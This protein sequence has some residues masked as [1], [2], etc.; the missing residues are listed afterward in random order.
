MGQ[1]LSL[2][3]STAYGTSPFQPYGYFGTGQ[4][5]DAQHLSRSISPIQFERWAADLQDWRDAIKETTGNAIRPV[6]PSCERTIFLPS[7][8][9]QRFLRSFS[10]C[11]RAD[12]K[13]MAGR[14]AIP[15][16]DRMKRTVSSRDQPWIYMR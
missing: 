8:Q 9:S 15:R 1:S 14:K 12:L 6:M 2:L 3:G 7:S 11:T 4:R 16:F 10:N 5:V 13:F